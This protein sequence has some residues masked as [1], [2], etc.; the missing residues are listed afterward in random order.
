MAGKLAFAFAPCFI[1]SLAM[2]SARAQGRRLATLAQQK[3]CAEQAK[4]SFKEIYIP[5]RRPAFAVFPA[6]YVDH[7]DAKANVCYVGILTV[8]SDDGGHTIT[9]STRIFD[10]FENTNYAMYIWTSDKAKKAWEVEPTWCT[11]EPPDQKQITCKSQDEFDA[12]V[13]K[14]LGVVFQ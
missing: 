8:E 7:Y 9:T 4:K 14:Y 6:S 5:P 1:L 3:M 11:V 12:L 2:P 10:A 13:K